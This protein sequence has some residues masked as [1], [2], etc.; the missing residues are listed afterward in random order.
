MA[1]T[2][3]VQYT[4]GQLYKGLGCRKKSGEVQKKLNGLGFSKYN[5]KG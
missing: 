2:P 4:T 5:F 1:L 3:G